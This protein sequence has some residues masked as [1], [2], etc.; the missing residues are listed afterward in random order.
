MPLSVRV[1][2]GIPCWVTVSRKVVVTQGAGDGP[3]C[4]DVQGVAGAVVEPGDDLH[5]V[6][7]SAVV[8][9]ESV[10]GEVGLPGLVR[11]PGFEPDVGGL[12]ALLR[13]GDDHAR[14]GQVA[15]DG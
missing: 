4:G 8:V 12:R 13:F 9:G 5:V 1:E 11:H 2:A 7:G 10:V 14:A 6:A 15:A 3:V